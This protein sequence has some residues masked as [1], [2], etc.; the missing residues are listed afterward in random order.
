MIVS[1]LKQGFSQTFGPR[2]IGRSEVLYKRWGDL[3]ADSVIKNDTAVDGSQINDDDLV[4]AIIVRFPDSG[5]LDHWAIDGTLQW[6][7][8]PNG[9]KRASLDYQLFVNGVDS[10]IASVKLNGIQ[11]THER[12]LSLT[13]RRRKTVRT[14]PVR[15]SNVSNDLGIKKKLIP[16]SSRDLGAANLIT[17]VVPPKETLEIINLSDRDGQLVPVNTT[18]HGIW[19]PDNKGTGPQDW[20][21]LNSLRED[22]STLIQEQGIL[23]IPNLTSGNG[24]LV[25]KWVR[26]E[27]NIVHTFDGRYVV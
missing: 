17:V 2:P 14:S 13:I 16:E 26:L 8:D 6:S 11:S 19:W 22:F 3:P 24:L 5:T 20:N 4:R 21:N 15:H 27:D 12:N 7:P 9:P 10:G 1:E 23:R 18:V 25:L